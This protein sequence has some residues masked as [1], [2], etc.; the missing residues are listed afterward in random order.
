MLHSGWRSAGS[1]VLV[2]HSL[3]AAKDLPAEIISP[4]PRTAS[5]RGRVSR[6]RAN[7]VTD[8]DGV[9]RLLRALSRVS[10]FAFDT[11]S[12]S[13][14]HYHE[15]LCLLQLNVDGALWLV[16][17]LA[18]DDPSWIDRLREPLEDPAVDILIHGGEFDVA[19][20]KRDFGLQLRG[21]WDTQQAATFLGREKTGYANL[22]EELLGIDLPK[23]FTRYD[24]QRR[25]LPA[26]PTAYA[27]D[28]VRH[29][30][31]LADAL[32]REVHRRDLVEEVEIAGR[33]VEEADWPDLS[34]EKALWRVKGAHSLRP[35]EQRRVLAL[36]EWRERIAAGHDQPPGRVLNNR[37]LVA[38]AER[39]P[40][41]SGE[42]RYAGVRR[43]VRDRYGEELVSL[44]KRTEDLPAVPQRPALRRPSDEERI[45]AKRI[46]HWKRSESRRRG[47]PQQA[48]LPTR[49]AD[50]LSEHGADDLAKV[51]QLGHKR[52]RLYGDKLRKLCRVSPAD[53][54]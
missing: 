2:T 23:A 12:N 26:G 15:R 48:V 35:V 47:I 24:W 54:Y 13:G 4:I 16:D 1:H 11:E 53:R 40:R 7:W 50:Y 5:G 10:E 9:G 34:P 37:A 18:F 39:P 49:A 31:D 52:T 51:P 28:D 42:L 8:S 44:L 6:P 41:R 27:L 38:L 22:V 30:I 33:A 46:R 32:R 14:F 43:E 29:L 25:P 19:S 20:M 36:L 45:R 21:L 17:P 3:E